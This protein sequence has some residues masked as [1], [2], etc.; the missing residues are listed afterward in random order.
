MPFNPMHPFNP[1]P[2]FI[3]PNFNP[4][5]NNGG[6]PNQSIPP[7][8]PSNQPFDPATPATP[9]TANNFDPSNVNIQNGMCTTYSPHKYSTNADYTFLF[10]C[11]L[12]LRMY[13]CKSF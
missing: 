1:M 5:Q 13:H 11:I 7:N 12:L 3:V 10:T 9:N 6:I 8:E 4:Y 2:P